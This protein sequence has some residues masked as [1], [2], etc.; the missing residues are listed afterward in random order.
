MAF[1]TEQRVFVALINDAGQVLIIKRSAFVGNPGKLGLPGGHMDDGETIE[2]GARRELREEL[3]LDIDFSRRSYVKV[4]AD[5]KRTILVAKMPPA[6]EYT[7]NI[8][9]HEVECVYWSTVLGL[10]TMAR[11]EEEFHK[12]LELALPI[13]MDLAP[14]AIYSAFTPGNQ[15]KLMEVE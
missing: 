15:T 4:H 14:N 11:D 2:A 8:D 13:L 6:S 5:K 10:V 1:E 9:E 12:S 3:G 7:F